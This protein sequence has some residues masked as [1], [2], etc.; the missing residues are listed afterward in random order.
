[1]RGFAGKSRGCCRGGAGGGG[2]VLRA[3][4]GAA[5]RGGGLRGEGI[6]PLTNPP[7][8]GFGNLHLPQRAGFPQRLR[9]CS[10]SPP[11]C[12]SPARRGLLAVLRCSPPLASSCA[13]SSQSRTGTLG[14]GASV[15][16]ASP[17]LFS[18]QS[19]SLSHPTRFPLPSPLPEGEG[20]KN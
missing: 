16:R 9:S 7:L 15:L 1:V 17:S 19:A 5:S 12:R 18:L 11:W 2:G 10:R 13:G 6:H 4:E 14:S 8:A 3:G 20:A